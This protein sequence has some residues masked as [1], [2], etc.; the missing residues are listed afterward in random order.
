[1]TSVFIRN[2]TFAALPAN[3]LNGQ[4]P[5]HGLLAKCDF[6]VNEYRDELFAA[7]GIP[8]PGSLNKAVINVVPNTWLGVCGSAGVELIG[9]PRLSASDGNGSC[10]AVANQPDWQ[11]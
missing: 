5:F 1:M 6:E 11:Y 4:P 8:F 3:G 9:Y 2:F 7:Y 10:A